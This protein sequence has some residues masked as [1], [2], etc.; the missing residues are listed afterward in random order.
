MS[1]SIMTTLA[2]V[3]GLGLMLAYAMKVVHDL[4]RARARAKA[5]DPPDKPELPRFS[6]TTELKPRVAVKVG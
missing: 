6:V 2:F 3:I 1:D 4:R 5:A